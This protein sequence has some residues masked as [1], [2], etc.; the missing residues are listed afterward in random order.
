MP[1]DKVK[2][3]EEGKKFVSDDVDRR[4]QSI[5]IQLKN[6]QIDLAIQEFEAL[7]REIR[8]VLTS[9]NIVDQS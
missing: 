8:S 3:K 4:L 6:D 2:F 9:I 5:S 1:A 7:I